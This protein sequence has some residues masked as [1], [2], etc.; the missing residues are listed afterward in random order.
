MSYVLIKKSKKSKHFTVREKNGTPRWHHGLQIPRLS[1]GF[2]S[3]LRWCGSEP[4]AMVVSDLTPS[5]ERNWKFISNSRMWDIIWQTRTAKVKQRFCWCCK[6]PIQR[7]KNS[8][9]LTYLE[10]LQ[11]LRR[12]HQ[13][14]LNIGSCALLGI[15]HGGWWDVRAQGQTLPRGGTDP[16]RSGKPLLTT[17]GRYCT[18]VT[19]LHSVLGFCFKVFL[20]N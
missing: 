9:V 13:P 20:K 14:A 18:G 1:G 7:P 4:L 5:R 3:K 12:L 17:K 2:K 19:W 10:R 16:V 6:W 11:K 8:C 15:L